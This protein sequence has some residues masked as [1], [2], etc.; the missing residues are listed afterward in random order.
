MEELVQVVRDATGCGKAE[1]RL[2]LLVIVDALREVLS[3]EDAERMAGVLPVALAVMLR[4]PEEEDTWLP[5][6]AADVDD[7]AIA[8]ICCA[9]AD[10]APAELW[11]TIGGQAPLLISARLGLQRAVVRMSARPTV[12]VDLAPAPTVRAMSMAS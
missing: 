12:R 2:A 3:V 5:R 4:A 9:L 6:S 10:R 7:D 8:A 1:A 11:W